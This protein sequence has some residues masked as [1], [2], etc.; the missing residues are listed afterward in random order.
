MQIEENTSLA[1][2]TTFH[3]GGP[4]RFFARVQNIEDIKES[5]NFARDRNL[6]TFILG[7][8]SNVLFD[9]VGFDGLVLKVEFTGVEE[10]ENSYVVGSGE[11]WDALVARAVQKGLWGMEN[12]SGIPG[13]VGGAVVQNIGAY[14][15]ALSQTLMWVEAYN[16][17]S[18]ELDK[19]NA[20]DCKLG[21][22]DS[23]FK[24]QRG[25]YIVLRACLTLSHTPTPELSYKDLAEHFT[26]ISPS[27]NEI[28]KTVLDIRERKFPKLTE[29][30]TAGS[31]FKNPIVPAQEALKLQRKYPK[32]PLFRLPESENIKI[33]LGWF[34]DYR[35]GVLDMRGIKVGGARMYEKQFLVLVVEKNTSSRDV[36]KLARLVQ[37]KIFTTCGIK[38]EPE[39]YIME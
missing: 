24:K 25:K 14:G 19:I 20:E 6:T 13:T 37:E 36:K 21:Y 33:P 10:G 3:I 11:S 38:I 34:L 9:D 18:G 8:G 39:V 30:G 5:L 7:G 1:L 15:Q 22:R 26:G 35:H 27:L 2:F 28:R 12:L 17:E 4:A 29:E 16:T 31:F 23:I 32:M